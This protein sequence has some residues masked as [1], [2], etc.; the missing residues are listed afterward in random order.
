MN[1][2]VRDQLEM[3]PYAYV[4]KGE[5]TLLVWQ[6]SGAEQDSFMIDSEKC[7]ITAKT[8]EELRRKLGSESNRIRWSEGAE[9][10]LDNFWKALTNLRA[11]R[12]SSK[13]T[14]EVLLEGWNFIEDLARTFRLD[15]P[16]SK[17]RSALLKRVYEK[18]FFGNNLPAVTPESKSYSPLWLQQ[19]I[20]LFRKEI[21]SI[22]KILEVKITVKDS[23]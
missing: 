9:I 10:S 7:L 23:K 15:K 2:Q 19:E 13:R 1:K 12:S 20:A 3:Y 18:L 4:Y 21:H 8:E 5:K 11:G 17:L 22:W 16:M 6:T 14:C